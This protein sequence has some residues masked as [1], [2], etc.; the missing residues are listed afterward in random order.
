MGHQDANRH[1]TSSEEIPDSPFY[2]VMVDTVLSGVGAAHEVGEHT[3][4]VIVYLCDDRD[5]AEIVLDNALAR[6]DQAEPLIKTE[7][8]IPGE[9]QHVMVAER[10]VNQRW[11]RR[12]GF[13]EL[14]G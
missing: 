14:E 2:V 4:Y 9:G 7:K 3:A 8:P 1:V 13:A 11:Y 6:D 10:S 5:E 12:G